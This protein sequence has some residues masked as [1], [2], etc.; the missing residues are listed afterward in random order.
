[1]G[2]FIEMK[3]IFY[4]YIIRIGFIFPFL[5]SCSGRSDLRS[6]FNTVSCMERF[7]IV[8][9]DSDR[10]GFPESLGDAAVCAHP[11]SLCRDEIMDVLSEIP[12]GWL[13]FDIDEGGQT[14]RFYVAPDTSEDNLLFVHIGQGAGDTVLIL[15]SAVGQIELMTFIEK[16]KVSQ[17]CDRIAVI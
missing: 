1:M 6:A 8:E 17:K 13:A 5:C 12:D 16:L 14:D 9:Y 15:F 2:K 11:N 4:R 3:A 10:Y 7:E